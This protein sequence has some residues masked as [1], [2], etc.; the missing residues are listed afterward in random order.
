MRVRHRPWA[1]PTAGRRVRRHRDRVALDVDDDRLRDE[2]PEEVHAQKVERRLLAPG[3]LSRVG[4]C[5]AEHRV[6]CAPKDLEQFAPIAE[7]PRDRTPV[8]VR[9]ERPGR[10]VGMPEPCPAPTRRTCSRRAPARA[11]PPRPSSAARRWP[12]ERYDHDLCPRLPTSRTV[13]MSLSLRRAS[14]PTK[15]SYRIMSASA[16]SREPPGSYPLRRSV[17]GQ[18]WRPAK[19]RHRARVTNIPLARFPQ[20]GRATPPNLRVRLCRGAGSRTP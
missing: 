17:R 9:L 10:P 4:S 3:R 14:S 12:R 6:D 15:G 1:V 11:V 16:R 2:L 5:S 18:T 13:S 7:V 19:S 20:A 8:T